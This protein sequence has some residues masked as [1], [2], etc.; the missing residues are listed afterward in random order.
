MSMTYASL[1][2]NIEDICE[3]DFTAD[4]LAM[5]VSQAET[6]IYTATQ[7]V[8]GRKQ[9]TLTTSAQTWYVVAPSDML[10]V[11]T[12]SYGSTG[13]EFNRT[14]LIPKEASFIYEA[15]PAVN[16]TPKYYAIEGLDQTTPNTV[17]LRFIIGPK[18]AGIYNLYIDYAHYPESITTAASGTTWLGQFF[19]TALLN[20][21]LVEAIRFQKGEQDLVALYEAKFKESLAL[22]KAFVDGNQKSDV[23]RN[24]EQRATR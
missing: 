1:C 14:P 13:T 23:Y 18:P 3:T 6:I 8:G 4:Q 2:T 9:G 15:Y 20:G 10:Y 17:K 22:F 11:Y 16:G 19:D 5:F 24:G 7:F 21:A 12:L